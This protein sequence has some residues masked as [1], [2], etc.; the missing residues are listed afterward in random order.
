MKVVIKDR[1]VGLSEKEESLILDKFK[2]IPKILEN[3]RVKDKIANLRV[4]KGSRWGY[5]ASFSMLLPKKK[6]IF[7]EVK[8]KNFKDAINEL[9]DLIVRQIREYKEKLEKK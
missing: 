8:G 1:D 6:H 9:K 3:F 5:K 7:A 2:D 4:K